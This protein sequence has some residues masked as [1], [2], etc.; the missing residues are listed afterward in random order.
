VPLARAV[1]GGLLVSTVMTLVVVPILHSLVLAR[2]HQAPRQSTTP[3]ATS[4]EI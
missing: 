2:E 1:V 3:S 4:E